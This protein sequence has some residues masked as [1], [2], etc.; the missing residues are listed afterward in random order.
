MPYEPN[1]STEA[2]RSFLY[3]Y[4]WVSFAVTP[5][6]IAA[7][8]LGWDNMVVALAFGAA[9]GGYLASAVGQSTD[10]YFRRLCTTGHRWVAVFLSFYLLAMFLAGV[11]DVAH[12]VGSTMAGAGDSVRHTRGWIDGLLDG[13]L[14][15]PLLAL[16]CLLV[17]YCGYAFARLRG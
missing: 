8:L 2:D 13:L 6:V 5:L 3:K 17:F 9:I 7:R 4:I 14:D 16:S 12:S 10:E 1:S 11:F 15:G